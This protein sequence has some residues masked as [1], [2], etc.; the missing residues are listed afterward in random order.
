MP[1]ALK[2]D[3]GTTRFSLGAGHF[4]V[5]LVLVLRLW[6]LDRLT[7][8]PL[9]MPSRGDMHFYDDWAI[10]ILHGQFTQPLGF[11]GL[12]GYAYFHAGIYKIFGENPFVTGL[13][14]AVLDAATAVLTFS[15][16]GEIVS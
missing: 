15:I 1:I 12:P 16:C 14:Q 9:L 11:Y 10:Q 6:S 5:L 2:T 3:R 13:L 8:S 4:L 7:H